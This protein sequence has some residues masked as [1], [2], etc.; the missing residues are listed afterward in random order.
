MKRI[1]NR[2][3][4]YPINND[5]I[6]SSKIS[7]TEISPN[8]QSIPWILEDATQEEDEMEQISPFEDTVTKQETEANPIETDESRQIPISS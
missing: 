4:T 2:N 5:I 6:L 1:K 8:R 3:K 7:H